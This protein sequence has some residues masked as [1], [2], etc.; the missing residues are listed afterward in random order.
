MNQT[1][2]SLFGEYGIVRFVRQTECS[3]I[4]SI[5]CHR[6]WLSAQT[7]NCRPRLLEIVADNASKIARCAR[8][9][10]FVT[11]RI[12]RRAWVAI[13]C[14]LAITESVIVLAGMLG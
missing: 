9:R 5:A 10:D 2:D 7:Q 8:D 14:E 1:I 12:H 6:R 13:R 3:P 11:S 4:G